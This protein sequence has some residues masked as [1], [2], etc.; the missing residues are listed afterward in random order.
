MS[1]LILLIED[2]EQILRGNERMLKRRGYT[3]ATALTLAEART[4][5]E[6]QMPHAIVLDIMLPD[7]SGLD[8]MREIRRSHRDA[9]H[10][11]SNVPI[12]LLTG[13]TTPEDV[14]RGL[15]EGGDDYL[16][17]PY[18]FDVLLARIEALLRRVRQTAVQFPKILTKG[19]LQLDIIAN[20]AFLDGSDMLLT[21]KEFA[22][23][24]MMVQNEGKGHSTE[25]LYE[26][27]WK[28]TSSSDSSA[29]KT[30]I[31]RLRSKLG[32][33]F[34]IENDK[35]KGGYVFSQLPG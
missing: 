18:D 15:S 2:N 35:T 28:G 9:S 7:G 24:L 21:P 11:I 6:E 32:I 29:V 22:L 4:R 8:F 34:N 3:V 31:S 5:L 26:T 1:T 19:A 14:V 27:I 13:L 12:L 30:A 20:R 33:E 10:D 25:Y 23:L 17:K 16:A